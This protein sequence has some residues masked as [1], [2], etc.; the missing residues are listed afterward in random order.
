[1]EKA[2]FK[3]H[4]AWIIFLGC[5]LLLSGSVG[6]VVNCSGLYITQ[7]TRSSGFSIGQF[8]YTKVFAGLV[9]CFI[10][11]I[12]ARL[13]RTHNIRVVLSI[14]A[15]IYTGTVMLMST[16]TELWHWIIGSTIQ[17]MAGA[18][19]L[20][21]PIPILINSWFK[22]KITTALGIGAT[23]S[24]I[25]AMIM[26]PI[27]GKIMEARGW[28]TAYVVNGLTSRVFLLP[29]T[30]IFLRFKPS[31]RGMVP[32][33]CSRSCPEAVNVEREDMC[34]GCRWKLN[35]KDPCMILIFFLLIPTQLGTG[36]FQYINAIGI[37]LG[38]TIPALA[39]LTSFA[40]AGN[41]ACKLVLSPLADKLTAGFA[42]MAN[43]F[44]VLIGV[45]LIFMKS[46]A[47]MST[48]FFCFGTI[49][50]FYTVMVPL[51]IR[52]LRPGMAFAPVFAF[53]TTAHQFVSAIAGPVLGEIY[54]SSFD[55][56]QVM[57]FL[58]LIMSLAVVWVL[59]KLGKSHIKNQ[60]LNN[61]LYQ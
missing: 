13:I 38:M 58:C 49:L 55:N 29:S 33:D 2:Q 25:T 8:S 32:Y 47:I 17:Q 56:L 5:C 34:F 23:F 1:M 6:I 18:F 14:A 41:F 40:S 7:V 31:D 24:G 45:G 36:Y 53:F 4:Y 20:F 51:I 3:I 61:F 48:A 43:L 46:T 16:F 27:L 19:L 37:S 15:L 30:A 11:P 10:I 35:F 28:R 54:D 26:S 42:A 59:W 44:I 9:S 12:A 50:P 21:L 60:C 22:E 39:T 52:H 57:S